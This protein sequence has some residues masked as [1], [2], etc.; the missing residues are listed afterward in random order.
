MTD[1]APTIPARD[2]RELSFAV[3]CESCDAWTDR[4]IGPRGTQLPDHVSCGSCGVPQPLKLAEHVD[5]EGS[6]DG[7]PSCG[8]H[9]LCIQK[10]V[11]PRLGVILVEGPVS[12]V[13]AR[14]PLPPLRSVH[15]GGP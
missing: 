7:C 2:H 13:S 3:R 8:Y 14:S 4:R 5:A 12:G 9:T 10:D 11:N 15:L 1:E 6:L